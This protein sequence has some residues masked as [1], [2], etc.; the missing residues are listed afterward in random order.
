MEKKSEDSKNHKENDKE[1]VESKKIKNKEEKKKIKEEIKLIKEK[2]KNEKKKEEKNKNEIA[3]KKVD[4]YESNAKIIRKNKGK[5]I[6]EDDSKINKLI[7]S[8]LPYINNAPHLGTLV[9]CVLSADVF[10][11]FSRLLGEN[12][13]FICGTDEYGTATETKAIQ[14]KCSPKEICDKYYA[15]HSEVYEWFDCDFDIFGRTSTIDHS[16]MTQKIFLELKKNGFIVKKEIEQFKCPNCDIVLADRYIYGTCYHQ[17]CGYKEARGDQCDKC[18]KLCNAEELIDSKCKTCNTPPIKIKSF[19]YFLKLPEL[20]KELKEWINKTSVEGNWSVN[21]IRI[22]NNFLSEGLKERCIT[23]DL[24]WGVEVPSDDENMKN[25]VFYVWFDAPIGY[26]S[27]T[28]N[29]L[30]E[31]NWKK[32][33]MNPQHVK[34]YQFMGKDN[35]P[36]HTVMFPATMLGTR[37]NYTMLY[38]L[39]STEYLNYEGTKFSKSRGIGVFGDMAKTTGIPPEVWRYYLLA[40]RPES[41]DSDFKWDDFAAKNNNE[42]LTNLGNL[43]NRILIFTE[44]NFNS[45]IPKF[46]EK[47]IDKED[48][49]FLKN[50]IQKYKR[51]LNAM[52]NIQIKESLKTFMEISSLG[53]GYFQNREPWTLVKKNSE[54]FNFAKAETLF[55][56]LC[57]F[58]R[59]IG[60]LAEPFMPSLSAKLYEILNIKYEGNS[61]ILLKLINDYIIKEK[62]K[63]YLFLINLKLIEEGHTINHSKPLFRKITEEEIKFFKIKFNGEQQNLIINNEK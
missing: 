54:K 8:A 55:Y 62:E 16:K 9:G 37:E 13:L 34:L 52:E 28:S 61:C 32:W 12:V 27:I 56:I 45:K 1:N 15:I 11:R 30:G 26:L 5:P 31:D 38:H 53:N 22:A 14:E 23:R 48:I 33:W 17:G 19:H 49:E 63:D 42:L 51:Y 24:K 40:I 50:L 2:K 43:I 57:S 21:S 35:V 10:A 58:I 20:E 7:T 44:K 3:Q 4:Y 25:K 46:Y 39:S 41:G 59:F 36:F 6:Y 29:F 47:E 60:A 18:G